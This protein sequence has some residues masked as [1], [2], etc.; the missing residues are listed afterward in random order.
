[1]SDLGGVAYRLG[2]IVDDL[3]VACIT[4]KEQ[5]NDN[6]LW[7]IR[8]ALGIARRNVEFA[9]KLI[10]EYRNCGL[11]DVLIVDFRDPAEG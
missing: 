6:D 10:E 2:E 9:R 7:A 11:P 8:E 1:M 4:V 5:W 3:T